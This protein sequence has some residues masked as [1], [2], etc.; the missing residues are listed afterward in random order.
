VAG[1]SDARVDV[2]LFLGAHD[3]P[4]ELHSNNLEATDRIE[5]L[6]AALE[7][8]LDLPYRSERRGAGAFG[9]DRDLVRVTGMTRERIRVR[10]QMRRGEP[11]L[12]GPQGERLR[13]DASTI[14]LADVTTAVRVGRLA[15]GTD[16]RCRLYRTT[17]PAEGPV[18][19]IPPD[20]EQRLR[21]L[22]YL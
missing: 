8:E 5:A 18:E 17:A 6:G 9:R 1:T 16:P 15:H 10:L 11:A 7:L 4:V 13:A 3:P 19:P 12:V 20:V 22:G 14:T 2:T 21:A